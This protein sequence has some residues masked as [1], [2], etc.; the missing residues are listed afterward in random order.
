VGGRILKKRRGLSRIESPLSSHSTPFFLKLEGK[1][2]LE[3]SF[4]RHLSAGRTG[5][6]GDGT[7]RWSV[8]DKMRLLTSVDGTIWSLKESGRVGGKSITLRL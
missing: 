4:S 5:H 7:R 8:G 3:K 2:R 1:G 6:Y